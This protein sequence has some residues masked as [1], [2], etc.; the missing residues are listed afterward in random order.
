[1][2][3]CRVQVHTG[4]A[5]PLEIQLPA[6][7]VQPGQTYVVCNRP[8]DASIGR[9]DFAAPVDSPSDLIFDGDDTIVLR[10]GGQIVDTIGPPGNSVVWGRDVTLRRK[11]V[12]P[13]DPQ[14][15]DPLLVPR[16]GGHPIV[17]DPF[18]VTAEWSSFQKSTFTDLR[19]Y[20]CP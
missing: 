2:S 10:C 6:I 11:C 18:D 8:A 14:P 9:C 7:A 3:S 20:A 1:M 12:A 4:A 13:F 15:G 5:T 16:P 17:N 19:V